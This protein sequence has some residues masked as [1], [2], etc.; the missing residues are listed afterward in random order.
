MPR[1]LRML[2][3]G[4]KGAKGCVCVCACVCVC[5]WGGGGGGGA[6]LAQ[7]EV[8]EDV[9]RR[10]VEMRRKEHGDLVRVRARARARAGEWQSVWPPARNEGRDGR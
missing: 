5:V 6:C 8:G 10:E 2:R 1:V 3:V 7:G 4:A 9:V